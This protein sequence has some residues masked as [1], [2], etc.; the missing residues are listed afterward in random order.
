MNRPMLIA[1]GVI[2]AVASSF[3]GL[4]AFPQKQLGSIEPV[5][6]TSPDG[7]ET[8]IP[9]EPGN[10]LEAPGRKVYESMGCVYCHSQQVRPEGFGSD[11][12]RG[13]GSRRSVPRDY[14]L[15]PNPLLGTMRTGPDLANIG[16]RQPNAAWHYLHLYNPRLTSPGSVMPP[17]TFLFEVMD[18]QPNWAGADGVLLPTPANGK[19][20]WIVPSRRAQELVAYLLS[21]KQQ[22][23]LEEVR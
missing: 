12:E 8:R 6:I 22:G 1:L 5:V 13:W 17:M 15:A 16:S 21:L 20:A 18:H 11:L 3:Y 2:L 19:P 9:R 23:T 10:W 4:I 7:T 14:A